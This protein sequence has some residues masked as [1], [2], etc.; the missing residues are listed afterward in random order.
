MCIIN[1]EHYSQ[2]QTER[3]LKWELLFILNSSTFKTSYGLFSIVTLLLLS[4]S[5]ANVLF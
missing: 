4:Q 3:L 5:D 1:T 2:A